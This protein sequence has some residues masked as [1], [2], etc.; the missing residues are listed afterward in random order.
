MTQN[1]IADAKTNYQDIHGHKPLAEEA[2]LQQPSFCL[3]DTSVVFRL[4][5]R[6]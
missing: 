4:W 3:N 5:D 6:T 1:K 2:T